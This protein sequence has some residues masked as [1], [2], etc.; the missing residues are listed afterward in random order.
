MTDYAAKTSYQSQTTAE[1]YDDQRFT[2]FRGRLVNTLELWAVRRA[3][4]RAAPVRS[5]LDLPCGTA[6]LAHSFLED[7]VSLHGADIS[8]AMLQRAKAKLHSDSSGGAESQLVRCDAEFLPY[9]EDAFD[10]TVSLRFTCHVPPET[11]RAILREMK[12]ISSQHLVVG[13]YI[14]DPLFQLKRAVRRARSRPFSRFPVTWKD[15][16]QELSAVGLHC[17]GIFPVARFHLSE[18]HVLLLSVQ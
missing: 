16:D 5:I 12:R 15:L 8:E 1:V 9:T 14:S 17:T 18:T 2:S 10:C 7:D 6:R 13:F 11:R 4:A 3:L